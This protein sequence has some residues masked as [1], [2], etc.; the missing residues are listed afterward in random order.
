[1]Y[2][3]IKDTLDPLVW[4]THHQIEINQSWYTAQSQDVPASCLS[5]VNCQDCQLKIVVPYFTIN[6]LNLLLLEEKIDSTQ[7]AAGQDNLT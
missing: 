7:R 6:S 2:E 3:E 1:M 4:R 5:T